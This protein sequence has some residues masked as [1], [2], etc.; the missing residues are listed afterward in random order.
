MHVRFMNLSMKTKKQRKP[1]IKVFRETLKS[2]IF[3]MGNEVEKFEEDVSNYTGSKYSIGVSSGTSALI[4]ALKA[5]NIK[6]GDE[7]IIPDISFIATA[8]AVSQVGAKVIFCDV[9]D[10][11]N[12]DV[13]AIKKLITS[14]TKAIIP[15]HYGGKMADIFKIN[16]IAKKYN[17][18]VIEDA[19]QSFGSR[20]SNKMAGT[21]GDIGCFSLNPM[22][23]LGALGEAG[24]ITTSS[25]RVAKKLKMLRYNGL[26]SKKKCTYKSFN[27]K[28]DAMQASFL[29]IRLKELEATIKKRNEYAQ[30]YNKHLSKYCITPKINKNNEDTVFAYTILVDK[31][32]RDALVQYLIANNIEVKI[33]HLSMHKEPAYINT[34]KNSL[35]NSKRV[36]KMKLALPCHENLKLS[37]IKYVIKKIKKF[38]TEGND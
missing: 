35:I 38:F 27:A 13:K 4:L 9:N 25:K 26:N 12:I 8:N 30:Y 32:K 33:N 14:K 20:K 28:I 19:S 16:K 6:D 10:D 18:I 31:S 29:S 15:V 37:E 2:G 36:S 11:F 21:I 23:P 5:Y 17:L 34:N 22:K 24:L 3:I 7:V 1:Y